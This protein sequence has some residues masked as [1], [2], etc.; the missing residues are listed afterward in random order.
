ME[1]G[2]TTLGRAFLVGSGGEAR[3]CLTAATEVVEAAVGLEVAGE[4]EEVATDLLENVHPQL[5]NSAFA[6]SHIRS[7]WRRD[8]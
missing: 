8:G 6:M 3:G 4:G 1:E 7:R 2:E 5:D